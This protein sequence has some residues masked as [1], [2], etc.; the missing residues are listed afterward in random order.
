VV[1]SALVFGF[2]AFG[3]FCRACWANSALPQ[4]GCVRLGGL[5][6][7]SALCIFHVAFVSLRWQSLVIAGFGVCRTSGQTDLFG[8][9]VAGLWRLLLGLTSRSK[10]RAARWRF[11][12]LVFYQGSVASFRFR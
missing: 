1:A 8:L 11:W 2:A 12:S 7:Y 6:P 4:F 3:L 10:G 9:V 5:V